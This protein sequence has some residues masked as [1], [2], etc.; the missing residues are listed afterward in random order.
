MVV[1]IFGMV[2]PGRWTNRVVDVQV[3]R[4]VAHLAGFC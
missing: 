4:V 3:L 1:V 2:D